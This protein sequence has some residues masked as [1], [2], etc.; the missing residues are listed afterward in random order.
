MPD[1]AIAIGDHAETKIRRR[2]ADGVAIIVV[3]GAQLHQ[4][5][6]GIELQEVAALFHESGTV[7]FPVILQVKDQRRGDFGIGLVDQFE[8]SHSAAGAEIF[9]AEARAH[10]GRIGVAI[11]GHQDSR[12]PAFGFVSAKAFQGAR[13]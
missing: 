11:L 3:P 6:F 10:L 4:Q 1:I 8:L 7:E 12:H 2:M 9:R 13:Q 5:D